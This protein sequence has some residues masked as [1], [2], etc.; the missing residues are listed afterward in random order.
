MRNL[1]NPR[2]IF[3]INTLP[4]AVLF[5]LL[6]GDYNIIKSQLPAESHGL[7]RDFG[8]AL[9]LLAAISVA[10]AIFLIAKG[11]TV[12]AWY[13]IFAF[14]SHIALL[15]AYGEHSEALIPR[16]IPLWM[17]SGDAFLYAGTFLMPTLA[18]SLFVLVARVTPDVERRSAGVNFALAFGIPL[19][20]YIFFQVI[21]P[22][23][24]P[25]GGRYHEHI[26]LILFVAGTV[27]FL[28]FLIRGAYIL[29]SKRVGS[30]QTH[31]LPWKIFIAI[32]FPLWGLAINNGHFFDLFGGGRGSSGVFGDFNSYWFYGL[33]VL[34]GLL[35]CLPNYED[36]IS[37][38]LLFL[39]RSLTFAYTFY[40]FLVFLPFLPFSVLA[41]IVIG[42]GFLMLTPLVLF[43]IHIS[44]LAGDFAFLKKYYSGKV[45]VIGSVL[46]FLVM[47]AVIT[48]LYLRDRSTLY[49]TLD[50]LYTPDYSRHYELDRNSLEKTVNV[51]RSH[52]ARN[53]QVM[54][55]NQT[56]YLSAYFNWLVLDNLTLSE[57]KLNTIERVFSGRNFILKEPDRGNGG[58][59]IYNLS[60]RSRYDSTQNAWISWLDLSIINRSQNVWQPEYAT[61]IALPTG[62]W[63]SD[64]YLYVG[65]KK[66]M[67]I[68]A[69]KKAALWVYSQIRNE[70]RDPGILYYLAGHRVAFRVFPFAEKEVR[71]TGIEFIH[72]DPVT[73][74]I[75]GQTVTLGEARPDAPLPQN[76]HGPVGYVSAREKQTLPRV[77]RTPYYHFL[78]DASVWGKESREKFTQRI[79][80]FLSKNP[81]GKENARVSFVDAYVTTMPMNQDWKKHYAAQPFA[82]GF[83]LDRAIKTTLF[84]A[85]ENQNKNYPVLVVVTDDFE[86]AVLENDLADFAFTSPESDLFF[87]LNE[88]NTLVPHSLTSKSTSSLSGTLNEVLEKEVLEYSYATDSAV[89]LPDNDEPSVFLKK[90][91]LSVNETAIQAKN[92]SSALLMQ[93]QWMAQVLHPESSQEAW[94]NLVKNSFLSK[95]MT[96]VTSYLVVE[97]EAQ[98]AVLKKK[99]EQVLA[100]NKSL[101][102]GEEQRMS[103]PG[104]WVLAALLGVL[105]WVGGRNRR[106]T[107]IEKIE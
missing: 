102:L 12:A 51:V 74:T 28:F 14:L 80:S 26:L 30:W 58:V 62:C 85:Y 29:V 66:E 39:G 71:R 37:R 35:I 104:L 21:A 47:P 97:N 55:S 49:E 42:V 7:W 18:Y 76:T 89:Y 91:M 22:L 86:Q 5:F 84:D 61:V 48:A 60:S 72:R 1:L 2:W 68:L 27:V 53:P 31:Q 45:L 41:I 24:Q 69:E 38:L 95:I 9:V 52:K 82:G 6:L 44:E 34:N 93:G 73:L 77:Q 33:A 25:T 88:K 103:E 46:A 101:D 13:G 65:D 96:P 63:V 3:L 81:D 99:Q 106:G 70:R 15:W 36:K 94:L 107:K 17:L 87:E 105:W 8:L 16:S 67:G 59:E 57:T 11:K 43:V 100:N 56:P 50:Y 79:E 90:K 40:F 75:D 64:Y 78:V 92:W 98:K 83:Y 20:W 32:V 23:W 54:S 4:L 19:F 10:Y